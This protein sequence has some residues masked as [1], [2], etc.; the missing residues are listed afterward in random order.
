[1]LLQTG[2]ALIAKPECYVEGKQIYKTLAS[3]YKAILTMVD[4]D[5]NKTTPQSYINIGKHM[6]IAQTTEMTNTPLLS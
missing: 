5:K 1:M 2:L 6:N 4:Q 3:S